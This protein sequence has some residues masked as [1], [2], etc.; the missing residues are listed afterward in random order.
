MTLRE[1]F[2]IPK[3]YN[4]LVNGLDGIGYWYLSLV[5]MLHAWQHRHDENMQQAQVLGSPFAKQ[6]LFFTGCKCG[7]VFYLCHYTWHGAAGK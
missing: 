4:T 3:R 2:E 7:Y 6:C 5:C 1:Q